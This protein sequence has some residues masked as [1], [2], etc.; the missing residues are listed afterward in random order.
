M[1]SFHL[2]SNNEYAYIEEVD[3]CPICTDTLKDETKPLSICCIPNRS[4]RDFI[5]FFIL[6]KSI[7]Y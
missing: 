4:I 2:H 1:F 6:D 3:I 7:I 5:Y